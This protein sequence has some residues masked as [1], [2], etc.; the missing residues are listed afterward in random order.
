MFGIIEDYA[1]IMVGVL[2]AP[3]G[4]VTCGEMS[5]RVG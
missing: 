3:A 4:F 2:K 5:R 1:G